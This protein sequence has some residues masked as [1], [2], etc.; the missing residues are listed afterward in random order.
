MKWNSLPGCC[1][2]NQLPI[3]EMTRLYL[4]RIGQRALRKTHAM[5]HADQFGD[6]FNAMIA[7]HRKFNREAPARSLL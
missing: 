5:C 3:E 1:D 7:F 6:V 4:H 2:I